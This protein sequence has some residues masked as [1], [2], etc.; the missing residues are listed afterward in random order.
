ML[1]SSSVDEWDW[2]WTGCSTVRLC[3]GGLDYISSGR[4]QET[5]RVCLSLIH[6]FSFNY[7]AHRLFYFPFPFPYSISFSSL[8]FVNFLSLFLY[9][10]LF[11]SL[12]L[13]L[14]PP[15]PLPPSLPLLSFRSL[16]RSKFYC[17]AKLIFGREIG[18]DR[19]REWRSISMFEQI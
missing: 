7:T 15:H 3:C 4:T 11:L 19:G 6:T 13:C 12:P 10:S 16:S 8:C 18:R 17:D 2:C 5:F 9:L 14:T 1:H